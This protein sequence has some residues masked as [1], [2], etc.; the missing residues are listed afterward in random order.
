M[1][2]FAQHVWTFTTTLDTDKAIHSSV[3]VRWCSTYILLSAS[4]S[5]RLC[6]ANNFP[7]K[8]ISNKCTL[9]TSIDS[10]YAHNLVDE[11]FPELTQHLCFNVYNVYF[12]L[13]LCF[14]Y[15]IQQNL[16]WHLGF[17]VSKKQLFCLFQFSPKIIFFLFILLFQTLI[18]VVV[19]KVEKQKGL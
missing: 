16:V 2:L 7:E 19:F 8:S 11:G 18:F 9:A 5:Y 12:I 15:R 13:K 4:V 1:F 6:A 17:K 14:I 3:F 10:P